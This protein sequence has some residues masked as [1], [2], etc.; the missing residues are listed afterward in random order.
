MEAA[1]AN[2]TTAPAI[3]SKPTFMEHRFGERFRCGT[4][5]RLSCAG[6][7]GRGRLVNVSLSGAYLQTTL[8]LAPYATLEVTRDVDCGR[9][10]V[11]TASVVRR[12]RGGFGVEWCETP[13]RSICQ[14]FG[15][16][17]QCAPV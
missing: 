10:I 11:L 3:A 15:C 16:G 9:R 1:L 14:I 12:D 6:V 2:P 4:T 7:A 8:D 17:K 5:V 13:G